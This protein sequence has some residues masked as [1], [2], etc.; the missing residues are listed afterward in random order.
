MI[1]FTKGVGGSIVDL[2]NIRPAAVGVDW[3]L[4]LQQVRATVGDKVALQGNL[5]PSVLLTDPPTIRTRGDA[6]IR[7]IWSWLGAYF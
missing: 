1:L 5:D 3:T 4:D 2:A 6:G 7:R